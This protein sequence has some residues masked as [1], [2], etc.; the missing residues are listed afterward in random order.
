[1]MRDFSSH[2]NWRDAVNER[3]QTFADRLTLLILAAAWA[4]SVVLFW[5]ELM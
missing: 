2:P 1:M 5:W 4:V 3:R